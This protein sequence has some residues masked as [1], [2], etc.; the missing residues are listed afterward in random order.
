M[1][2]EYGEPDKVEVTLPDD[3][4]HIVTIRY[5]IVKN[6]V[7]KKLSEINVNPGHTDPGKHAQKNIGVSVIRAGRELELNKSFVIGYNPAERW[8]GVEVSFSPAL[9]EIF[10]VTNNKQ[11]ATA[12]MQMDLDADAESE[13]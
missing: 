2:E 6:P 10:G 4:K 11:S 13:V 1:F 9:D 3:T 7:R 12:F 5:S 8:W